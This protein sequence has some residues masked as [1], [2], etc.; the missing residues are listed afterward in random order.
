MSR[1]NFLLEA[2]GVYKSYRMGTAEVSVLKGVDLAVKR[3]E[4][5]AIVGRKW[6]LKGLCEVEQS[7]PNDCDGN[8]RR[9]D[10]TKGR[11]DNN[12]GRW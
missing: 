5:V 7:R 12:I 4:F 11:A 6:Y 10:S 1:D 9:K 2:E 8:T 3:G